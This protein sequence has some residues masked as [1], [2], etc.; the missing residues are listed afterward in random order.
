LANHPIRETL[1]LS[2]KEVA[3]SLPARGKK[4]IR[5][6]IL[7][8]S[9]VFPAGRAL[10]RFVDALLTAAPDHGLGRIFPGAAAPQRQATSQIESRKNR[11]G[12]NFNV[13]H[14]VPV[15]GFFQERQSVAKDFRVFLS[16]SLALPNQTLLTIG[17]LTFS[18]VSMASRQIAP[19]NR[20]RRGGPFFMRW[21]ALIGQGG[22]LR[23]G[24]F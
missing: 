3:L 12:K 4:G 19:G 9:R 16:F 15:L 18:S 17:L 2:R 21:A 14:Y 10:K 23:C 13:E 5:G 20:T 7:H 11:L 1:R 6:V 22:D 8:F 24:Y